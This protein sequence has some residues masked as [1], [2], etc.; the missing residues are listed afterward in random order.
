MQKKDVSHE[1]DV[2]KKKKRK[3]KKEEKRGDCWTL[4][5]GKE[6]ASVQGSWNLT[7]VRWEDYYSGEEENQ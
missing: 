6:E 4:L 1:D 5:E 2:R 7:S 3:K